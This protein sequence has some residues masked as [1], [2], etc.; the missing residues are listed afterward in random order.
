M[1]KSNVI[2]FVTG[3]RNK[4]LEVQNMLASTLEI[5]P[6]DIDLPE[7]QGEPYEIATL[8]CQAALEHV[9]GPVLIEDT[10]LCFNALG[11]LPGPYIK[12]F[13]KELKPE[14]LPKLLAAFEDKTAYAL[15][16][17]AYSEGK[18]QFIHVFEGRTD[19]KIVEPRGPRTFGW[20][21][22]FEPLGYDQTYA[23]MPYDLKK[24]ISNRGKALKKLREY[25]NC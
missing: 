10:S 21:P 14:G 11:G 24:S 22:C 9:D 1:S 25:L 7:Y 19:G 15:C 4:L 6:L 5:T 16:Y 13:L 18:G 20:D 8:K 3:N 23:E 12:W 2:K 17:F